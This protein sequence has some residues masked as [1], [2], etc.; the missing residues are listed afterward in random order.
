DGFDEEL[1]NVLRER[2]KDY[3]LTKAIELE[4]R[5]ESLRPEADL[6]ALDGMTE[7]MALTLAENGVN[8]QELLAELG[9][10]ELLELIAMPESKASALIMAARAPW[11]A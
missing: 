2:A 1:V 10:D 7:E 5:K 6:L 11:F 9:V 8:T 3:L 4:E